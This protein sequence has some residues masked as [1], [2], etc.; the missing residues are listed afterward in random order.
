[1]AWI[2]L[3]GS[4]GSAGF[5]R[6]ENFVVETR[7]SSWETPLWSFFG[8]F[9]SGVSIGLPCFFPGTF[10]LFLRHRKGC[11][12][13]DV[14]NKRFGFFF[15]GKSHTASKKGDSVRRQNYTK[16]N[17]CFAPF[18]KFQE[19]ALQSPI[20]KRNPNNGSREEQKTIQF[21]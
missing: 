2:L 3:P 6:R 9:F 15:G 13:K 8:L 18:G 7:N 11:F 5:L 10:K 17:S 14:P 20:Q 4:R 19:F 21:L 16:R 1:M 12:Q